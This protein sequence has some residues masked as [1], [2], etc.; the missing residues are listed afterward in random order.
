V[1]GLNKRLGRTFGYRS[2]LAS[3]GTGTVVVAIALVM[4]LTPA[5]GTT[6]TH[7]YKGASTTFSAT[8]VSSCGKAHQSSSP[9]MSLRTG[10]GGWAGYSSAKTPC[11]TVF[12]GV[13]SHSY[14]ES[15]GGTEFAVPVKMFA[16]A[17]NVTANWVVKGTLNT[18]V[19][20][21]ATVCP[22]STGGFYT[23]STYY[24][25][26]HY[27]YCDVESVS[28]IYMYGYVTDLTNGSYFG[29]NSSSLATCGYSYGGHCYFYETY[30]Y[31]ASYNYTNIDYGCY[32]YNYASPVCYAYNSSSQS[33]ALSGSTTVSVA[34]WTAFTAAG[35]YHAGWT[36]NPKDHYAMWYEVY[37]WNYAY[38]NGYGHATAHSSTNAAQISGNGW[39][40]TS[41][42]VT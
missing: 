37:A 38:V 32:D 11:G 13:G 34:G 25:Q 21:T 9:K 22:T 39:T 18:A 17:N 6:Y 8:D 4:A 1:N 16:G 19:T 27:G 12:A 30:W 40:L 26:Y 7:P 41:Y 15:Q 2:R 20:F 42:S 23:N 5:S 10:A 14:G 33:A 36:F 29:L 31:N 28:E 35:Q 24:D 3:V